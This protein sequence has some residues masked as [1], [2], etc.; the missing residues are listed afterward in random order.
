MYHIITPVNS[1]IL[2]IGNQWVSFDDKAT[3]R[4]KSEYIR[5]MDLGGGMIWALDLD[6]FKNRC[7][8]G[9]HPLLTIIRNVL[10]DAGTGQQE[11]IGI[12]Y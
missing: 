3:I 6:D 12:S 1:N 5:K 4:R 2:L 8:E 7:G 10:A 11:S 9:R